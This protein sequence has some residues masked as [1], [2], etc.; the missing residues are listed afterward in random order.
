MV[1]DCCKIP[2]I[3]APLVLKDI[4]INPLNLTVLFPFLFIFLFLFIIYKIK[5]NEKKNEK[6]INYEKK[7]KQNKNI[8]KYAIL[9]IIIGKIFA[10]FAWEFSWSTGCSFYSKRCGESYINRYNGPDYL[11]IRPSWFNA[12]FNAAFDGMFIGVSFILGWLLFPDSLGKFNIKF[13][14][15]VVFLGVLQNLIITY[16]VVGNTRNFTNLT[17]TLFIKNPECKNSNLICLNNQFVW[18]KYP[19]VCYIVVLIIYN[20]MEKKKTLNRDRNEKYI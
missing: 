4:N 1:N 17:D 5:K 11:E 18:V 13:A 20:L 9:S 7:R 3:N 14:S 10:F 8:I 12:F 6:N 19:L 15:F 16:F 2:G